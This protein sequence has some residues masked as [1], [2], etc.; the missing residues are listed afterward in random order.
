M[1]GRLPVGT[2]CCASPGSG[3]FF[4][5]ATTSSNVRAREP[6]PTPRRTL[7][8]SGMEEWSDRTAFVRRRD[9]PDRAAAVSLCVYGFYILRR[10]RT[11]ARMP[12]NG[13]PSRQGDYHLF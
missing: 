9:L 4:R 11:A 6:E 5:A 12:V 7:H 10:V 1:L 3:R 13:G 8:V 2:A